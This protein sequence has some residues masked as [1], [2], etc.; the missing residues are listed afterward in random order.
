MP[1]LLNI[2]LNSWT[3]F[4]SALRQIANAQETI[5]AATG[6]EMDEPVFRGLGNADWPLETTLERSAD[7]EP[8]ETLLTY[9]RR[10]SRS[11]PIIESLTNRLWDPI[12]EWP[13]FERVLRDDTSMWI[14]MLLST[15]PSIYPYLIYLRHHGFPSPLLDWTAS[16]YLAAAFAFDAMDRHARGIVIWAYVRD[17]LQA[18]G[19]NAHLF[20]VG[21][22]LRT[23]P[24]H[25][26]QQSRYSLCVQLK[27]EQVCGNRRVDYKFL[28][29]DQVLTGSANNDLVAKIIVP[30]CER[31]AALMEL[32]S[33]NINPYSLYASEDSLIRT[34]AR[35]EMLFRKE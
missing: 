16:P 12:P 20:V 18:S 15:H 3:E 4:S 5:S 2:C 7:A 21:Q 8:N 10:T 14:D 24:R 17:K 9:Y 29:H 31:K 34:V 27:V 26:L 23:H 19:S 22:Y 25:Y 28:P 33:M 1:K 11:K 13:E 30:A 35:R 32:D 6:R